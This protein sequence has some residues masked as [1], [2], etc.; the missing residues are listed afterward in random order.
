MERGGSGR[1]SNHRLV[2][3]TGDPLARLAKREI[4]VL[5]LIA[6]GH[7]ND[8]IATRLKIK[9]KTVDNL[10]SRLMLKLDIHDRVK[11]TRFAIW[12]G[13]VSPADCNALS[14]WGSRDGREVGIAPDTVSDLV[15]H[16]GGRP[17][18]KT[19]RALRFSLRGCS[20]KMRVDG[21][22]PISVTIVDLSQNGIGF[23][24][25]RRLG[26]GLCV[27]VVCTS[28]ARIHT[29]RCCIV[30]AEPRRPNG[31]RVGATFLL[32]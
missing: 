18:S 4:D 31:Y 19:R 12:R 8:Q 30:R 32:R 13:L 14:P 3:G 10:R 29:W 11:L 21:D 16:F 5:C 26:S 25:E 15:A 23:D 28:P 27:G 2:D 1:A 17:T 24:S 9:P 7:R 6:E 20:A 22:R